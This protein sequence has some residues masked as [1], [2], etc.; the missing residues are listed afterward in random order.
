[1][2]M[3]AYSHRAKNRCLCTLH[4]ALSWFLMWWQRAIVMVATAKLV[5]MQRM[6]AVL[7]CKITAARAGGEHEFYELIESQDCGAWVNAIA[8]TPDGTT[9]VVATHDSRIRF[10]RPAVDG[11]GAVLR[12]MCLGR[13]AAKL[14]TWLVPAIVELQ[15]ARGRAQTKYGT[16]VPADLSD[17]HQVRLP[18]LPARCVAAMDDHTVAVAGWDSQV[19]VLR[20][21]AASE[22]LSDWRVQQS[23]GTPVRGAHHSPPLQ[24]CSPSRHA[25]RCA[26]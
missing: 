15:R 9:L 6:S 25:L 16:C 8:W 22:D 4:G 19:H 1:M 3:V 26:L 2:L 7:A 24:Q 10:W 21:P 17:W 20:R 23:V 5:C 11:T 13:S 12:G 18:G 14:Y